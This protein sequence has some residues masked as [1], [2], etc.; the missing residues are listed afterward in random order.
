MAIKARD[1]SAD[2]LTGPKPK[3]LNIAAFQ[4]IPPIFRYLG[5]SLLCL[6][7][8]IKFPQSLP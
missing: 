3:Y 6:R 1:E 7:F 2:S 5:L 4:G 8:N